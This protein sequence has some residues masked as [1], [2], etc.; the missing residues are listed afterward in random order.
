[1]TTR[2]FVWLTLGGGAW[3]LGSNWA[4]VTDG[5][6]PSLVA[7]G[8]LDSVTVAGPSGAQVQTITGSGAVASA[9]FTG[10]TMLSGGFSLG[11]LTVGGSA[12]G[13]LLELGRATS[14]QAS[15]ADIGAGSVVVGPGGTLAVA[16][17]LAMGT[18]GISAAA[19]DAT[20][21]GA[22][23][24]LAL[25]MSDS[26]DSIYVDAASIVEVGSAGTGQAGRLT[27]DAGAALRGQGSA[28]AYGLVANS[29]ILEA[30]GGTLSVGALSGSGTLQIDAGA[31]L[32]LNG[33]C[34]SGQGV[35]FAG[36]NATLAINQEFFA[37]SGVISGFAAGDAFDVR[38]SQI[39]TARY[40]GGVLT[41]FYGGQ[42]AAMLQLAGNYAG[43]VF[44]T[45]GDGAGGTS[46]TVAPASGGGSHAS[47]GTTTP[48]QYVWTAA[49]SGA[50]N[51]A[52]NWQ[53]LTTGASPARIAPGAA[54]LVTIDASQSTFDVIS[55]PANAA[56][57]ALQGEVA[58][59]GAYA[60]GTLTVGQSAGAITLGTLDLLAGTA[61]SA[62]SAWVADGAVSVAGSACVLS[63]AGTLTLG[64][65][66]AGVGLPTASLDVTAGGAVQV[67]ALLMG[68]GSGASVTTDPTGSVEIGTAG[69][70]QA[71]AV[72]IDAGATLAGNGQVDP[73]G[74]VVDNGTILASGGLA[75][76]GLASGGLASGGTL[77]L[78][79]VSGSGSLAVAAGATLELYSATGAAIVLQ[80]SASTGGS[81]L[82]FT[83]AR[84]APTGTIT[85]LVLGDVIHLEGSPL[86]SAQF[87]ASG[88]GGSLALVYGT[89]VVARL[90]LAGSLAGLR[91]LV[92]P[93]GT[94][95][96]YVT[97]AA[98]TGGGGGTGQ[99][100]TDQLA[101]ANPVSGNWSLHGNWM[102]LTTGKT[103]ALP[104]GL[105]TPVQITGPGGLA[106]QSIT[107][108]GT[109]AS[110]GLTGNTILSGTFTTA[111]LA[112]GQA[113]SMGQ[114]ASLAE[115]TLEIGVVTTLTALQGTLADGALLCF[116]SGAL[117]SVS[118]TLAL[119]GGPGGAGMPDTLLMAGSHGGA[120]LG[121][122]SLGGGNSD[123]V[124]VDGTA[125]IEVGSAGNAAIGAL[126]VDAGA[127]ASGNGAL[128]TSGPVIDNG[129]IQAQGGTLTV[130]GVTGAGTLGIGTE[131]TLAL[132]GAD[133]CPIAFL[134]GGA[135]LLLPA[136]ALLPSGVI[137]GFA[138]GDSIVAT[139]L[140]DAV[141]YQA[142]A[143]GIGTLTLSAAGQATG[144]LL[145]AG[146]FAGE[147]F[148]VQP[149]GTGAAIILSAAAPIGPPP[150]TATP[151]AYAWTG[152]AG[153]LAWANAGNWTDLTQNTGPAAVA[154]GQNDQVVIA[155]GS[156]VALAIAG[157]AD[158][159][160][161]SLS[162]TV[163]L[164][165]D[166]AVGTLSVGSAQAAGVLALGA[167]AALSA[168]AA[169]V[170]GGLAV[171]GGV[172]SVGGT[173]VLGVGGSSGIGS[174][175][176]VSGR[177]SAV[178][179]GVVLGGAGSQLATDGTGWIEIGG[180]AGAAA[181]SIAIDAGGVLQG[182]GAVGL[183][184]QILDQGTIV[185]SGGTLVLGTV[186]GGG[187]LLAG[188]GADLVLQGSVGAGL[189]ADFAGGGTLTL[190]G[191][192]GA[193]PSIADFG[194]GDTI[195]LPV[196]GAASA[197]YAATGAGIGVLSVLSA[198]GQ[199]LETLT[200]LGSQAG[201]AFS[202]ADGAGGAGGGSILTTQSDGTAG[203]GGTTMT[204][205][206]LTTGQIARGDLLSAVALGFSNVSQDDMGNLIGNQGIYLD[207]S[208]DGLAP[209]QT[210]FGGAGEVAGVN[211]EV[212]APLVQTGGGGGPGIG[213]AMQAGY[214]AVLLE[215][216]ENVQL[217]DA[218][219][220]TDPNSPYYNQFVGLGHALLAG[221]YG[222]D[223]IAAL[224]DGD[225]LVGAAGANTVFYAA[226]QNANGS[227]TLPVD[228]YV[229]GGGNDTIATNNDNAAV[230][231]SGGHSTVFLGA[232]TNHVVSNGSDTIVCGGAGSSDTILAQASAGR[233]GDVVFTGSQGLL[234]FVGGNAP[235]T[236]VGGGAQVEMQGGNGSG[237]LLWGGSSD[238]NYV[239][240][241]GS[242]LIVAGSGHTHVQGGS[243]PVTVFGGT[244]EG[245]FSGSAGSIFVVGIGNS[246]VNAVAGNTVWITGGAQV[247][248]AGSSGVNVYGG[249]AIGNNIFQANAGNETLWGGA[250]SD[251][252]TAGTGN[253]IFVS[254]GGN[255]I[256]NFTNGVA[257]GIDTV[258]GFVPGQS[259]IALHGFGSATPQIS[260][261]FGDSF[262]NLANGGQIILE[263]VTN[264][265]HAN[266]TFT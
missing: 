178:L 41:L 50:W 27:I 193:G 55:G 10:N 15:A 186:S 99:T 208:T 210:V 12:A 211:V 70:A 158:A 249:T 222:S 29:G 127:L 160:A 238:A 262:I 68:G 234:T 258:V 204:Y 105:Q 212:V 256:F 136:A 104:P 20:G 240:G 152:A 214:S 44:L 48:D 183:T 257:D 83:S 223:A 263:N 233:A 77:T 251:Q 9:L 69:G 189:T 110:L 154:P 116:G 53:D 266:F 21:G 180:S 252:F 35:L 103:A 76:G 118:G 248:V 255:D 168:A 123:T 236:V 243:G 14:V 182:A 121:G 18:T 102:D 175:L 220:V 122:L 156:G 31:T 244:G 45:A 79:A 192:A 117:L 190:A 75:S 5:T 25:V 176:A 185:A 184:G 162:G 1:M 57:L 194:T 227:S 201:L 151:D 195:L 207:Y 52:G 82:A 119:G 254:G 179:G 107:G 172:F 85:G 111:Q 141:G 112:V 134:G 51:S 231:T 23:A 38:G 26:A 54:N 146:N 64:G 66:V 247:S 106:F 46:V 131:A 4:D 33:A 125:W 229:H 253:D 40:A 174:V 124:A 94:G 109:C 250:G 245:V 221:N 166:Y 13:G 114:A 30:A 218:P 264:L 200:L 165:G 153:G 239:G 199:V 90:A 135:T 36:A 140:V 101:W 259:T 24:V 170:V 74:T 242:A 32:A 58:L 47:P 39:S 73:F 232:S 167:G 230:T 155:G 8:A 169:Q 59:S 128:N 100:G 3:S 215:G 224:G 7:P 2:N 228:V 72:T 181:G 164:G 42:V 17:T 133:S 217:T 138:A 93:D 16:G 235:S 132:S 22:A 203:Q 56:S 80:G 161:L 63:V 148:S 237:G 157:P 177:G 213:I 97:L 145:L 187:T 34:G 260:V 91:F 98:S 159:A 115:G 216:N 197:S 19:L 92:T 130:G 261:A 78:G 95:G 137:S 225:T 241:A 219:L 139:S 28:N 209:A 142:G 196:S 198:G 147:S 43:D 89:T 71:G 126:T 205:P 49:G 62:G 265:T 202:V 65:G 88:N 86:G 6:S 87:T 149:D 67:G 84:A 129:A 150:G 246:T 120:Q 81:T 191:A 173:L 96:T 113:A 108:T 60:I 143:G 188:V 144:M 61:V 171:G 226:L 163:S 37:P 11:A 206:N